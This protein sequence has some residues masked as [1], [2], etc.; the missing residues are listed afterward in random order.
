MTEAESFLLAEIDR[1]R[2]ALA[3]IIVE[4]TRAPYL[5]YIALE[6]DRVDLLVR[7]GELRREARGA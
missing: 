3:T 6:A 7:Q 5:A 2:E 1:Y 4:P